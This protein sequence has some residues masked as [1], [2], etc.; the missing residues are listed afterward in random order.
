M[1]ENIQ[2][3][4]E[5]LIRVFAYTFNGFSSKSFWV[6]RAVTKVTKTQFSIE[7]KRFYKASGKGHGHNGL[8]KHISEHFQDQTEEMNRY[9][10][11]V[12]F[13]QEVF[14]LEGRIRK[15][16]HENAIQLI[17]DFIVNL[18]RDYKDILGDSQDV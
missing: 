18:K 17:K 1:F 12:G 4:D 15:G 2:V 10:T 11:E 13:I 3:G 14:L 7:D 8:V 5:V 6:K 9:R 16:T